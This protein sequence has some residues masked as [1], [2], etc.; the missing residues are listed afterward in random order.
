V[1]LQSQGPTPSVE[2][3]EVPAPKP[4]PRSI[5]H[6]TLWSLG[7]EAGSH[8]LRIISSLV[9]TRLLFPDV[10]G[11][12][13]VVQVFMQGLNM[14][15]DLGIRPIIIRHERG[16]EPDF[17]NTIWTVRL[18]RG[19]VLSL[20]S[21]AIAWP[22]SR[23]YGQPLLLYLL[24][25]VSLNLLLEGFISTKIFSHERRLSQSGPTLINF[26]SSA[27]GIASMIVLAW[28]FRS[29]WALVWGGIVATLARVLLSHVALAG[30]GNRFHWDRT[31]WNEVAHF[32]KWV[33][34][35]SVVTFLA[36]QM[37]K[38]VFAKM[39]PLAA[40]GVY[41]IA[42]NIVQLPTMAVRT[43]ATAVAFPA[44]SC[45]RNQGADLSPIFDRMRLMLLLGGG[46]CV[47]FLI[48]NGPWIITLL[49]D[50]RYED[51]GWILQ[52]LAIGAWFIILEACPGL[53]LLSMGHPRWLTVA[54]AS[55]I[56]VMAAV[57]PP[58][59][60]FFG[61]PGALV[62]V[63][64]VEAVR[65]A[66]TSARVRRE[67]LAHRGYEWA[68]SALVLGCGLAAALIHL[69]PWFPRGPLRGFLSVVAFAA[70]WVPVGLWYLRKVRRPA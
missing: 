53:M 38:L 6:A 25:V 51:A 22:V 40:L 61:F 8:S 17:L 21:C 3:V 46:A 18:I 45:A 26:V 16:D 70:M 44:F 60:H 55:K 15:S 34:L 13:A 27:L 63:S 2:R 19:G 47:S 66:V 56:L 35:N 29:V 64:A 65:Y 1:T 49:Y 9:L 41:T 20:A 14:F 67:G 39:I 54:S 43:V 28:I 48:L 62:A 59:F 12:M 10:F 42:V 32:G 50:P 24:P 4:P 33:F 69:S 30:P 23:F 11:L 37:D 7:G 5:L 36:L 31:A 58:A 68:T 57:V 52:I